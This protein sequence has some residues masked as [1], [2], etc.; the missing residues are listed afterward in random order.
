MKKLTLVSLIAAA[1]LFTA[2]EKE[3]PAETN[4]TVEENTSVEVNTTVEEN[5]TEADAT[6]ANTTET[7]TTDANATEANATAGAAPTAGAVD[8]AAAFAACSACHG[9]DGKGTIG[10]AK[11]LAGKDAAYVV[12]KLKAYKAGT[13]SS[14]TAAVMQGQVANLDDATMQALGEHVATLK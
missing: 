12:E 10:G 4:T 8:G 6:E 5:A 1:F 2:C 7:N 11:V 9:A 3:A 13:I 14:P